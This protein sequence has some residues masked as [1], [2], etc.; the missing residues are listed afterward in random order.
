[1]LGVVGAIAGLLWLGAVPAAAA[2]PA[3][4]VIV[5]DEVTTSFVPVDTGPPGPGTGDSFGVQRLTIRPR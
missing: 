2:P 5:L 1:M 3:P 4:A